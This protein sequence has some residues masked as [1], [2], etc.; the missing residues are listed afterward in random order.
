MGRI[1]LNSKFVFKLINLF[2]PNLIFV[3]WTKANLIK[4][5]KK[6]NFGIITI[7]FL[8]LRSKYKP[9]NKPKLLLSQGLNHLFLPDIPD[10]RKFSYSYSNISVF[11]NPKNLLSQVLQY[12]MKHDNKEKSIL[13][14][15]LIINL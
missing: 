8:D 10:Y 6:S 2:L 14:V 9:A 13:I 12:L 4:Y 5:G 15:Y 7:N 1:Y 3:K 11:K